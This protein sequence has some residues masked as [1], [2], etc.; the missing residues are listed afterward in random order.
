MKYLYGLPQIE[1]WPYPRPADHASLP[2]PEPYPGCKSKIRSHTSTIAPCTQLR[3]QKAVA[4]LVAGAGAGLCF[5]RP[6]NPLVNLSLL[7]LGHSI[8]PQRHGLL[9]LLLLGRWL[10]GSARS[11]AGAAVHT[12]ARDAARQSCAWR[13]GGGDADY[14]AALCA[15]P[16]RCHRSVLVPE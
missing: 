12:S 5:N 8:R 15:A 6:S 4:Y 14:A 13:A 2:V 10:A 11:G 16:L 7:V 9:L 3:K 1:R